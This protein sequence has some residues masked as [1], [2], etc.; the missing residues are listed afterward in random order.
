MNRPHLLLS[1]LTSRCI[2]PPET[3][4][5]T[6][7]SHDDHNHHGHDG[8]ILVALASLHV[9]N[10]HFADSITGSLPHQNGLQWSPGMRC[11]V[12]ELACNV[13]TLSC[14]I[15][16]THISS[17]SILAV[18]MTCS[19]LLAA[20]PGRAVKAFGFAL[21]P[22]P[23]A[24]KHGT[25]PSGVEQQVTMRRTCMIRYVRAVGSPARQT[26]T[27][28]LPTGGHHPNGRLCGYHT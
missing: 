12:I 2:P 25:S 16:A 6:D 24:E 23:T 27:A 5:E 14:C 19:C 1:H 15:L 22:Y 11:R 20:R 7:Q 10:I 4:S 8:I 28:Y 17:R 21:V 9:E 3:V 18:E 26:S 13:Q